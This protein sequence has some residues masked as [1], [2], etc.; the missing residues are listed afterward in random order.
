MKILRAIPIFCEKNRNPASK[1]YFL[2]EKRKSCEIFQFF[3]GKSKILREKQKSCEQIL[4][5]ARKMKILRDIP[6][7]RRKIKFFAGKCKTL[8]EKSISCEII[9]N[10]AKT[11]HF[12]QKKLENI[13]HLQPKTKKTKLNRAYNCK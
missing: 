7:L 9:L 1:S 11:F 5:S 8:R 6:I 4:F 2:R 13:T 12:S 3:A 10:P